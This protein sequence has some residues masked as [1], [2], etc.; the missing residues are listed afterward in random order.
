MTGS[1]TFR[2]KLLKLIVFIQSTKTWHILF[3]PIT[4]LDLPCVVSFGFTRS[5]FDHVSAVRPERCC[6]RCERIEL[7]D[8]RRCNL[9]AYIPYGGTDATSLAFR[10]TR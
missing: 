9:I 6:A 8:H 4:F 5:W 10:A 3:L 2:L 7:I 1:L